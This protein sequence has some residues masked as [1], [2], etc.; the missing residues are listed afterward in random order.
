VNYLG[1]LSIVMDQLQRENSDVL[2]IFV[3]KGMLMN[4]DFDTKTVQLFRSVG[5]WRMVTRV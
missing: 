5:I 4:E 1:L 2:P 3:G